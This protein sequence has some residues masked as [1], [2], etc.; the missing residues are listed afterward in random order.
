MIAPPLSATDFIQ[1]NLVLQPAP[2]VPE[3]SLYTAHPASRV[4]RLAGSV[5]PYWAYRWAGGTVLARYVLDHPEAVG[6]RRVL[7]LGAGSGIVGIAAMRAGAMSVL[8]VDID[9][10]AIAA[11]NLNAAAN[12]VAVTAMAGDVTQGAAPDVDIVLGGDVFYDAAVAASM[13]P[14]LDRCHVAGLD[15]LIGDPGRM[16]LPVGRL[17]AVAPYHVPDFGDAS[18]IE[19]PSMIYR[20]TSG[21]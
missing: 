1:A 14:F 6:G 17:Q 5:A 9:P 7:D 12:G 18:A 11:I 21:T 19:R 16:P 13:T 4:S 3:L 8:A 15:I 20:W 10:N 2:A